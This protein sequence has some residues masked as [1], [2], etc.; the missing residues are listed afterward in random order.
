MRLLSQSEIKEK[1]K[2]GKYLELLQEI[3]KERALF[4]REQSFDDF[5]IEEFSRR[6]KIIKEI[7]SNI[8]K[9]ENRK[10]LLEKEVLELEEK[11]LNALKPLIEEKIKLG[12]MTKEI[13]EKD[14]LVKLREIDCELK[15]KALKEKAR[16]YGEK[17]TELAEREK[18]IM[19]KENSV[20][21]SLKMAEIIRKEAEEKMANF[22]KM[23]TE[24]GK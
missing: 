10:A 8:E 11:R 17:I 1:S 9:I 5:K 13:F 19:V 12:E 15:E 6:D 3:E 24:Y 7:K 21:N 20:K 23:I 16:F 22:N 2:D 4:K 14:R 18:D